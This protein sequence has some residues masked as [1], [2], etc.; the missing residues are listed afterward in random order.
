M[1]TQLLTLLA[2]TA[3]VSAFGQTTPPNLTNG[4]VAFYPFEG[5]ANDVSGNGNNATTAGNY[6]FFTNG[7]SGSAVRTIGDNSQFYSGGGNVLLPTFD[8]NFNSGFTLSF[9]VKDEVRGAGAAD[10]E[11]YIGF[12]T[13]DLTTIGITLH[14]SGSVIFS[15]H[16]YPESKYAEFR[17]PVN[18]Q[19]YP[20]S[21][22]KHIVLAYKLGS[23]ACFFNGQ[24]LYETNATVNVFPVSQAALNRHWFFNGGAS[25]ARMSCTYDTVRIWNRALTDQEVK[26]IFNYDQGISSIDIRVKTLRLT[27]NLELTKTY[28]IEAST[29][30]PTW[31]N[32]GSTFV[33]TNTPIYQDVDVDLGPQFFRLKKL[34]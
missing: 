32:Y 9:W 4:L 20:T 7:L 33:A 30:L 19:T 3:L 18:L 28:Q 25:S 14:G 10:S 24:K 26:Q 5:N 21:G 23:F 2:V 1:K 11:D 8:S 6:Q 31:F 27:M 15:M 16:N 34:P 29:N 13:S 17:M 12:G 22:W